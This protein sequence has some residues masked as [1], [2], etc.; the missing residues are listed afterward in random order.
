[1]KISANEILSVEVMGTIGG[2][3]VKHIQTIGGL[4]LAI[5]SSTKG[6]KVLGAASHYAILAFNI[7][8]AHPSFH[9]SMMKSERL[10]L[11]HADKHSHF[12][13][14][15][16]RKSGHDIYSVQNGTVVD[17]YVTKQDLKV[18]KAHAEISGDTLLIKSSDI[19]K[20]FH[21]GFAG[22]A[23]EKTLSIG[24]KKVKVG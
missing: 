2:E 4:N 19:S 22:A 17:F 18:G 1:M 12:L 20:E 10:N 6:E 13:S 24:L 9:P 3:E 16:L 23:G 7:E 5:L 8:K 11:D 14:D 21:Q 15:T